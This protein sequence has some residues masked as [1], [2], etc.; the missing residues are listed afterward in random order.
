MG[1]LFAG[2]F[3]PYVKDVFI[4]DVDGPLSKQE[5]VRLSQVI[6]I[7]VPI[8]ATG[9]VIAEILPFLQKEQLLM[10]LTS[11]KKEPCRAMAGGKASVIG[12]HPLFG[13]NV[14]SLQ[15]QTVALCPVREGDWRPWLEKVL[16]SAGFRIFEVKPEKHDELMA[17]MQSLAHFIAMAL[18]RTLQKRS[19]HPGSIVHFSTPVFQM[20]LYLTGRILHQSAEL[21]QDIQMENPMFPEILTA[22]EEAAAQLKEIDLK[23]DT[24]AFQRLYA[25]LGDFF[26]E[27]KKEGHE[28]TTK[29]I[30]EINKEAT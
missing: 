26:G 28:L 21:Y 29:F 3:R 18:A 15:G 2:V 8:H 7:T 6:I 11:L 25:E 9:E 12:L 27:F 19:I 24:K 22:F 4:S 5:L 16:S 20:L 13:P 30:Q 17:V 14:P 23:K 10:D 1:S